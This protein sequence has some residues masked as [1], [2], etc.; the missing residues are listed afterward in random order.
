MNC[1]GYYENIHNFVPMSVL[2]VAV[3]IGL[4]LYGCYLFAKATFMLMKALFMHIHFKWFASENKIDE[5]YKEE[6][7]A[8]SPEYDQHSKSVDA[9]VQNILNN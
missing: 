9:T 8:K 4:I 7:I 1:L 6:V 2:I 5:V 3:G